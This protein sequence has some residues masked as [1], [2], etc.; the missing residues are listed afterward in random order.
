M[1]AGG[2]SRPGAYPGAMTHETADR[3]EHDDGPEHDHT[4]PDADQVPTSDGPDDLPP[5]HHPQHWE[6]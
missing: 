5:V 1:Q 4:L 6:D 2:A 3:P